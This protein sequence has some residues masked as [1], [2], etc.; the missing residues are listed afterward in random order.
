M[1]QASVPAGN[2]NRPQFSVV[3]GGNAPAR[4]NAGFAITQFPGSVLPIPGN[5]EAER[6]VLGSMLL[7]MDTILKV[8]NILKP[9]DFMD[10]EHVILYK[11]M[12][13]LYEKG[14]PFDPIM[15]RDKIN[16]DHKATEN[17]EQT[18]GRIRLS[19]ILGLMRTTSSPV[20]IEHYTNL[21]LRDS[22]NRALI[23]LGAEITAAAFDTGREVIDKL[24]KARQAVEKLTLRLHNED[25]EFHTDTE[26]GYKFGLNLITSSEV[27]QR[28][29]TAASIEALSG[30]GKGRKKQVRLIWG[31]GPMD[32]DD[33]NDVAPVITLEPGTL[34][35]CLADASVG[36]TSIG[37]G[38]ALKNY[39]R[40]AHVAYLHH[41]LTSEEMNYRKYAMM[42][43][44]PV[45]KQRRPELLKQFEKNNIFDASTELALAASDGGLLEMYHGTNWDF[46]Q[47]VERM[48]SEHALWTIRHG[49]GID[50]LVIDYLQASGSLDNVAEE[51]FI[52]SQYTKA[53]QIL[54]NQL[55]CTIVLFS[56]VKRKET[57]GKFV[58]PGLHDALYTGDFERYC[59][60]LLGWWREEGTIKGVEYD[61]TRAVC[62]ILKNNMGEANISIELEFEKER[63]LFK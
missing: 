34:V 62:N 56:Q 9:A 4:P 43:G 32:G 42:S 40:G 8:V 30:P 22:I 28:E 5:L 11:A 27:K 41:E 3:K 31:L 52:Y 48:K 33:Y 14:V 45:W 13:D 6:A 54:A 39:K 58:L 61:G 20:Y 21:V 1:T 60:Q 12:V 10:P 35:G 47:V 23:A 44:V 53:M 17:A 50:L 15:L 26:A 63:F 38:L 7:D 25:T 49:W 18:E 37:L 57:V 59:Y 36:K 2:T 19:L 55:G 29:I 24:E 16:A 51:R 46:R